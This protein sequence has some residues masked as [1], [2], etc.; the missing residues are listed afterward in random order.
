MKTVEVVAA[1]SLGAMKAVE[2]VA[3]HPFGIMKSV[4]VVAP[5]VSGIMKTVGVVAPH[6]NNSKTAKHV[7]PKIKKPNIPHSLH[8]QEEIQLHYQQGHSHNTLRVRPP[9]LWSWGAS[10]G[11]ANLLISWRKNKPEVNQQQNENVTQSW[12][13]NAH[14]DP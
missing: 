6:K 12:T 1:H 5:H 14:I 2:V 4:E 10:W 8:Q 9:F 3:P 7:L 11:A 13:N